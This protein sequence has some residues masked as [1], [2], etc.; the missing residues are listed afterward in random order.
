MADVKSSEKQSEVYLWLKSLSPGLKLERLSPHFENRGFRSRRSLKYLKPDDLDTFFDSPNKLLLAEKRV[1]EDELKNINTDVRS[2][3]SLQPHKLDFSQPGTSAYSASTSDS[4]QG[5]GNYSTNSRQNNESTISPLDRRAQE[6][7]ENLQVLSVQVQSAK[8]Q[9]QLKRKDIECIADAKVQNKKACG[10]CH[11]TGHNRSKC[12]GNPCVD[13][14]LCKLPDKHPE[15][16]SEIRELQKELKELEQKYSKAKTDNE[17]FIASRQRI[18]SSFF[19]V[20]RPRL[21]KQNQ[22]KYIDRHALDR[23]LMILQRALS[24]KIPLNEELD[25]RLPAVIEE[26]KRNVDT[27]RSSFQQQYNNQPAMAPI[28]M[29]QSYLCPMFRHP[30]QLQNPHNYHYE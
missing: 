6:H 9:L 10:I 16:Q 13:V 3:N 18:R 1:I 19:S 26:Y 15:L 21:E 11:K 24:G 30:G 5:W 25:W 20:M 12:R 2:K 23:D 28:T 14:N 4:N 22:A 7:T 8:E 27:Y 17:V 29:S